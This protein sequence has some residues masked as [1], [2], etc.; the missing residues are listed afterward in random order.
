MNTYFISGRVQPLNEVTIP[1]IRRID[2]K[3]IR[4][5]TFNDN[6]G[7]SKTNAV[8]A[9]SSNILTYTTGINIQNDLQVGKINPL[10]INKHATEC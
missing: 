1:P 8:D 7:Q 9:P 3:E 2:P 5:S 6:N 4:A 10:G